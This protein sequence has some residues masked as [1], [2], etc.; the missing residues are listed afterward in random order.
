MKQ[1]KTPQQH[2]RCTQR[3]RYGIHPMRTALRGF[4]SSRCPCIIA[5]L[6]KLVS[7]AIQARNNGR[8]GIWVGLEDRTAAAA[9]LV[10]IG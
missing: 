9:A 4:S 8:G 7:E 6:A 1:F 3:A 2:S 5:R 10:S